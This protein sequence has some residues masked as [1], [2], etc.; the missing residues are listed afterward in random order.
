MIR[1][2]EVVAMDESPLEAIRK[3]KDSSINIAFKLVKKGQADAET[4]VGHVPEHNPCIQLLWLIKMRSL[5]VF[6]S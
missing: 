2:A 4:F 5:M 1:T 3:K 6:L